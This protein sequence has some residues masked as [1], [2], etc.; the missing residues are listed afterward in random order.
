MSSRLGGLRL[1]N[2]IAGGWPIMTDIFIPYRPLW[3]LETL[4]S[5]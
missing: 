2:P 3:F 4:E 1:E 5:R